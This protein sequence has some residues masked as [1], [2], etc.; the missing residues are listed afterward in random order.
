MTMME[1]ITKA[2]DV[3]ATFAPDHVPTA[4]LHWTLV[5]LLA[6]GVDPLCR[7]WWKS[8]KTPQ[9]TTLW[10]GAIHSV[11]IAAQVYLGMVVLEFLLQHLPALPI[12]SHTHLGGG[13]TLHTFSLNLQQKAPAVALSLWMGWTASTV[14]R[15]LLSQCV[16]GRK[17]GRVVLLDRLLDFVL[18]VVTTV[19]IMDTLDMDFSMGMQSLLS[20]GGVGA[21][22]FSLAS[23]DLAQGLVGGLAV[24]AWDAFAVGD[25]IILG[26]GTE[27]IVTEIGLVETH[28]Q[29]YDGIVTRIP[30]GQLTTARVS[31][32]SRV[33]RS[34]LVQNLR[35]HYH[36]LDKLP[37]LLRDMKQE[38]KQ[39][40]PS[41]ITDGSAGF[42]A[43]LEEYH[44]DHVGGLVIANFDIPPRTAEFL[45]NRQAFLLA[46]AR[47]M[48]KHHVH[49]AIPAIET[50]GSGANSSSAAFIASKQAK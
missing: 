10:Y 3:G 11:A 6:F 28:L 31:N 13:D 36:D 48:Q 4:S 49:F 22:V 27:G 34:R 41:V 23:Q 38:I 50:K 45:E 35:F 12:F 29:G 5:A 44:S 40:C 2:I 30:N 15:V 7:L 42:F 26:D 8:S 16:A 43:V 46:I 21:L 9:H 25:K 17:L 19:N 1:N 20:A 33:K 32:L 24:Q 18:L 14:K 47:A 39:G 37:A